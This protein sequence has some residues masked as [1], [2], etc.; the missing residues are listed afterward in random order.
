MNLNA[1]KMLPFLDGDELHAIVLQMAESPA[2]VY[3]DLSPQDLA[4]F[5]EEEDI[6]LLLVALAGK[7]VFETDL[8]PFATSEA[9]GKAA[10][11]ALSSKNFEA[12]SKAMPFLDEEDADAAILA[13]LKENSEVF[14]SSNVKIGSLLPFLSEEATTAL[15]FSI[16][17]A[18]PE[19]AKAL[20]PHLEEEDFHRLVE[21]AEEGKHPSFDWDAAYPFLEEEDV[22]RLFA[23]ALKQKR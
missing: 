11:A 12:F 21:E 8:Y 18:K 2:G 1:K 3:D 7:G 4:P 20:L 13:V 17:D 6:D 23:A 9:I 16:V 15:F 10:Q 22:K 5:A 19:E 14:A